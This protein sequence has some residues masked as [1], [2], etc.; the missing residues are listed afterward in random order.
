MTHLSRRMRR[1]SRSILLAVLGGAWLCAPQQALA[2]VEASPPPPAN[3]PAPPVQIPGLGPLLSPG[4]QAPA[5]APANEPRPAPRPSVDPPSTFDLQGIPPLRSPVTDLAGALTPDQVA[6]LEAKLRAFE[7]AKG[8]QIAVL[9]VPSTEPEAIEQYALRVAEAWKLGRKGIDDGA[10]LLVAVQDRRVRIETGYG[11]EGALNDATANRI[12]DEVIV[13]QF[14]RGDYY[15]GIST[16]VDRMLRVV[17]G[18]PLPEPEIDSPAAGIPGLFQLLPV[19]LVMLLF[20]GPI[21]RRMFGRVGGSLAIGGVTSVVV[22][23]LAGVFG[24]ALIAGILAFIFTLGGGG[25]RGGSGWYS[26]PHRGGVWVPGGFGGG[27]GGGFGGG[28]FGGGG[29]GFGGGG[30]SGSW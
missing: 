4:Q 15:G 17:E 9:I 20:V 28:G 7:Q 26:R 27:G 25:G 10:L 12:I 14:R 8:S 23:M 19:L 21:L 13:P 30:A 18:E 2:Q 24:M 1:A 16:G 11:L 3:A 22:Y 6:A 5:T 29:G